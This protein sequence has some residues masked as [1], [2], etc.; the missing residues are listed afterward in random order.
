MEVN[1]AERLL[2]FADRERQGATRAVCLCTVG[3]ASTSRIMPGP[4]SQMY[5]LGEIATRITRGGSEIIQWSC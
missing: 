1:R 3:K 4:L 2:A 5:S